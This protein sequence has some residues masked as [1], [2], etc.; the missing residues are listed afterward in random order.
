MAT[1]HENPWCQIGNVYFSPPS[2]RWSRRTVDRYLRRYIRR[3]VAFECS[4]TDSEG[5]NHDWSTLLP[6]LEIAYNTSKHSTIKMTPF[7]VHRGW[8]PRTPD[9]MLMETINSTI[10]NVNTSSASFG[11][12]FSQARIHATEC[13]NAAFNAS[14]ARWDESHSETRFQV[15]DYVY[16]STKH[17][18]LKGPRKT[19]SPFVG[20]FPILKLIGPNAVRVFLHAPYSRKHDVFPLITKASQSCLTGQVS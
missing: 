7:E 20:P 1:S 14:K 16:I 11:E 9:I 19:Q 15:G 13:V 12:M 2:N 8:L 5:F 17:F 4:Y 3:Y 6:A 10:A 18:G